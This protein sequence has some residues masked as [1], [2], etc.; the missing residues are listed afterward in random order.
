MPPTQQATIELVRASLAAGQ[1][2][3][4]ETACT[5]IL[6]REPAHPAALHLLGLI[7][8]KTGRTEEGVKLVQRAIHAA[9]DFAA[10]HQDLGSMLIVLKR[11]LEAVNALRTAVE[12]NPGSVEAHVE[13]GNALHAQGDLPAAETAYREALRLN[14]RHVRGTISLGNLLVQLRRLQEGLKFLATAVALAPG[15]AGAHQFLGNVLRDL[16]RNEEAIASYQRA[17]AIDPTNADTRENLGVLLKNRGDL[18]AALPLLTSCDRDFGKAM[19]L[20]CLL[21]LNRCDEFFHEIEAHPEKQANNLYS[22]SLSAYASHHLGRLDPHPF[23]PRPLERVKVVDRYTSPGA[24]ADFLHDLIREAQQLT[25]IWEPRGITTVGGFQTGGNIFDHGL[26]AIAKLER[27]MMAAMQL[28]R[29]SLMPSN[30]TMVTHWPANGRLHGW[31]VRLLTGGHQFYHNHPYGWATGCLYLQ[32]PKLAAPNEGAIEFGLESSGYPTLSDK[33][34]P[35]L[36]HNPRPGQVAFFPSSLYHR[37][38]PFS[39]SEERM[40]IAFDLL[41]G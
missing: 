36:V 15:N 33:E 38:I 19:G 6:D 31:F 4:A 23:C 11:T 14:P 30:M 27:D 29:T 10:A 25:A 35:T 5:E 13:F 18:A 37:T 16:D 32:V 8:F 41:P 22:A 24:N 17:L 26:P 3:A 9:P 34:P 39:S 2:A 1:L 20:E 28:Y 12:L 40:C 21:R 7:R